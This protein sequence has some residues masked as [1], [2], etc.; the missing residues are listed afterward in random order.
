VDSAKSSDV[1]EAGAQNPVPDPEKKDDDNKD[2]NPESN[3][4][5]PKNQKDN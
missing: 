5:D 2:K 4:P 3:N 1:A